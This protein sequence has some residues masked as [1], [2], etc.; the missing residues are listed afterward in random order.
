L[1]H[2]LRIAIGWSITA[3]LAWLPVARGESV[4]DFEKQ[5][6]PILVEH[7]AKCHGEAKSAAK[8]RLDSVEGLRKKLE[9]DAE[10]IVAG[11]PDK[12]RLY[13]RLVL[14]ASDSKRMPKGGDPLSQ[15]SIDLI[16]AWIK[17]GAVLPTSGASNSSASAP[18]VQ[19]A[20]ASSA[21]A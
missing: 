11:A 20:A 16:A 9:A 21:E 3:T 19:P 7:C 14:P 13:E 12:S 18:P 1:S 15:E 10:L 2:S 4:V 5:I 6:Q 8:M 17:Q